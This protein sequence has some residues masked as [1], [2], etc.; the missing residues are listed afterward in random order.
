MVGGESQKINMKI[1]MPGKTTSQGRIFPLTQKTIERWIKVQDYLDEETQNELIKMAKGY[2]D[3]A[4][5]KFAKNINLMIR[6]VREKRTEE[7]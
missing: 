6:R 7:Q 2:P 3:S 1:E 4:L 5:D